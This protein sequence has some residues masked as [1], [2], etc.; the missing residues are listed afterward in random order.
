M[1]VASETQSKNKD[2]K[3]IWLML[4][5]AVLS[6]AACEQKLE[7][8]VPEGGMK[9][10]SA[11][12]SEV[13]TTTTDGVNVK[14]ESGD[15]IALF[16]SGGSGNSVSSLYVTDVNPPATTATFSQIDAQEEPVKQGDN[17]I[18]V[19]PSSQ[20]YI[21]NSAGKKACSIDLPYAQTVSEPGWDKKATL[22]A[23]S[24]TDKNFVFNHCVA[25][26]KFTIAEDSPRI[27]SFAASTAADGELIASRV[28]LTIADDNTVTVAET[29]PASLQRETA[30]LTMEDEDEAFPDGTYYLAILPKTYSQGF[31][32]VFTDV[33]GNTIERRV[34]GEVAM[35]AGWVGNIG[36]VRK[37]TGSSADPLKPFDLFGNYVRVSII[38]DSI[39]T[40]EGTMPTSNFK[41]Y[42]P[43]VNPDGGYYDV[44]DQSDLY[45]AKVIAKMSDAVRDVN[46]SWSGS[47]VSRRPEEAYNGLDY[48]AR[49]SDF[50]LGNPNVI[51]IHGGTNDC[52][53]FSASHP[54]YAN[55]YRS[56]LYDDG[57]DH[58]SH[59]GMSSNLPTE[60]E[61]KAV[62]DAA[63]AAQTLEQIEALRDSCS[64]THAYVKL[65]TK[66]HYL[67]PNAKVVMIIGD[68]LTKRAQQVILEIAEHYGTKY[69]YQCVNFFGEAD[70]IEKVASGNAHPSAAG[71]TYMANKIYDQTK[72]YID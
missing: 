52:T 49:V 3:L 45:W 9:T 35:Q 7:P 46:N 30:T 61:Y 47:M 24:S 17:Y 13:K 10:I 65:I 15:E 14:W 8:Q 18:A 57:T 39:S 67:Y 60:L 69:G 54:T 48:G 31:V 56:N 11:M 59:K 64:F 4:A 63:D 50:G 22:L 44:Q 1:Y 53:K 66:V 12:T 32:F 40:F 29:T 38:G 6:F 27:V 68:Q 33:N 43:K 37:P 21:W 20:L 72:D 70:N 2:M 26:L 36:T 28:K 23:A 25:Y 62:F 19:Y 34:Q 51:L 71:H 42:Y 55:L 41:S 16:V 58:E 5:A